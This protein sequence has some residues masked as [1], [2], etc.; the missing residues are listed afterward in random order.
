MLVKLWD[1]K[2]HVGD[3][4][5]N[6]RNLH[7]SFEPTIR[8]SMYLTKFYRSTANVSVDSCQWRIDHLIARLAD[9]AALI[10][11]SQAGI[12]RRIFLLCSR[13]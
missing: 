13:Q 8:Y 2:P 4:M 11:L 1:A 7:Y 9:P 6:E 3:S 10:N 5:N 12:I